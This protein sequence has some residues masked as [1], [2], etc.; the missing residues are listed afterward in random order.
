MHSTPAEIHRIQTKLQTIGQRRQAR[1][2]T[3]TSPIP[4]QKS[5]LAP[6]ATEADTAG[7]SPYR[8]VDLPPG[9]KVGD[10]ATSAISA[11]SAPASAL[12]TS[13]RPVPAL[14]AS[15]RPQIS[16]A[17]TQP[18][19]SQLAQ[20]SVTGARVVEPYRVP[21][22]RAQV[23]DKSAPYP[24]TD[25]VEDAAQLAYRLRS[26]QYPNSSV[27]PTSSIPPRGGGSGVQT[28]SDYLLNW[29]KRLGRSLRYP[30]SRPA[31]DV[32]TSSESRSPDTTPT[33]PVA[34]PLSDLTLQDA[35]LW[36]T[37]SAAVRVGLDL[38]LATYAGLWLPVIALI[39]AP[40]AIALYRTAVNPE[41][42]FLLG[43]RLLLIM[44]G[45]LLGGRML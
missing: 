27:Y 35:L 3:D 17:Q 11:P 8:L 9:A 40:A 23:S 39:T 22:A 14:S 33:E 2:H 20:T 44:I 25:S 43:R 37:A 15:S 24:F 38:L 42:G 21:T 41:A 16:T 13:M 31:V 36:V 34:E 18:P 12:P 45:L 5:A 19:T 10:R 29:G 1:H 7:E 32:D 28:G 26:R 30:L 4:V 6:T